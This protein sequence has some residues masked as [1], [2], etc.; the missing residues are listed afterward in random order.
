MCDRG[1]LEYDPELI[2][3]E[4][5]IGISKKIQT[6]LVE[7]VQKII[8]A[9]VLLGF[10]LVGE[11][12]ANRPE[13]KRNCIKLTTELPLTWKSE[14]VT[15]SLKELPGCCGILVSYNTFVAPRFQGKGINSFLQEIKEDIARENGYTM[16]M[17]TVTS[18]N[19]PEIH[20]LDKYGWKSTTN[21]R[22]G[23]TGNRVLVFTKTLE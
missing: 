12:P 19:L 21:F 6:K 7:G 23:R 5:C 8:G 2:K 13:V 17:A 22:N 10:P 16:L 4:Y 18:D 1:M 3:L 14:I 11:D 20:I 9:P 15:F